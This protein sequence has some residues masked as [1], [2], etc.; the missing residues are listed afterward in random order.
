MLFPVKCLPACKAKKPYWKTTHALPFPPPCLLYTSYG[1]Q[2]NLYAEL[3]MYDK[4][5]EMNKK[6]LYYSMLKDSFGLGDL[7]RYRAQIF[8]NMNQKDS[9]FH[10]LR[11]GEKRCV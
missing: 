2:A 5:L 6:A 11:L 8:R 9:V 3:G 4:D 1:E 10:Y 7:Y